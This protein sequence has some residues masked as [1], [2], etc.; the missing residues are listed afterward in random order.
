MDLNAKYLF[1]LFNMFSK[2]ITLWS[3]ERGENEK[4]K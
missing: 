3:I 4:V 2:Y 1:N